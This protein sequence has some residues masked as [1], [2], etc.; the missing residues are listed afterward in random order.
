MVVIQLGDTSYDGEHRSYNLVVE[1]FTS[2]QRTPRRRG[3]LNDF[4]ARRV[5]VVCG[6][7]SPLGLE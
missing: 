1:M 5:S 6:K 3:F 4:R 7:Q 2:Q